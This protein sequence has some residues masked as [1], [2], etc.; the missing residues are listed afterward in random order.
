MR[1][2]IVKN[3]LSYTNDDIAVIS[4]DSALICNPESPTDII[5][6]IEYANVQVLE[7]RYY[8]RELSRQMETDV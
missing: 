8:D 2:E 3:T 7:L 6:L 1:E 5:D 4:W